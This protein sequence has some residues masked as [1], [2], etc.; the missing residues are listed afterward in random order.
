MYIFK[1]AFKN[2]VRNPFISLSSIVVIGLLIFFINILTFV[3]FSTGKFIEGVN[4]RISITIPF[5]SGFTTESLQ[6]QKL[7]YTL[8]TSF[9]GIESKYISQ[10]EAFVL[11]QSRNPDLAKLIEWTDENPLPNSLRLSWIPLKSYESVE[12][13]IAEYKDIL[14]YNETEFNRKLIDFQ[15]QYSR[16]ESLVKILRLLEYW[17]YALL[18]LFIFT[19]FV[20]V[21]TVISNTIFFLRDEMSIIELVGGRSYFIYGPLVIQWLFYTSIASVLA[22]WVFYG[23]PYT[24]PLESLPNSIS[25][26]LSDFYIF[27]SDKLAYGILVAI[28]LGMTSSFVASWK[29]I[30]KT[31]G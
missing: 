30:H 15:S 22:A 18:V 19:V 3:L 5:Q 6:T 31:I 14:E 16:I 13:V 29:Y 2:I 17:V 21:Y 12:R 23:L 7:L 25:I 8:W 9:S 4:D 10:D 24:L 20:V 28:V 26:M 1:Y 27:F 11:F